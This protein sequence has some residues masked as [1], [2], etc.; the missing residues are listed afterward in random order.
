M[1]HSATLNKTDQVSVETSNFV[2]NLPCLCSFMSFAQMFLHQ[3]EQKTLLSSFGWQNLLVARCRINILNNGEPHPYMKAYTL[4]VYFLGNRQLRKSRHF[5]SYCIS[6]FLTPHWLPNQTKWAAERGRCESAVVARE[7][8]TQPTKLKYSF[9]N[10]REYPWVIGNHSES[11]PYLVHTWHQAWLRPWS[12]HLFLHTQ[13]TCC[14]PCACQNKLLS[15]SWLSPKNHVY[16][17][18]LLLHQI[19]NL[20]IFTHPFP[21]LAIGDLRQVTLLAFW[22]VSRMWQMLFG[23]LQGVPG[24][25]GP[26]D[27][28][29]C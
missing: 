26:L 24:T 5:Q 8:Q 6:G 13:T 14:V 29:R 11:E 21:S 12:C 7:W 15:P 28:P 16:Y 1:K 22:T 20:H 10:T 4:R 23:W 25:L 27:A 18:G 2:G 19:F 9:R 17:C 3:P